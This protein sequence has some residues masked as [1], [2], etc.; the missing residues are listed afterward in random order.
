MI[1]GTSG[2]ETKLCQPAPSQ[3]KS[4]QTRS[5]SLGSRKTVA[6]FDPCCFRFS[7][8]LVEKIFTNRSKSSTC[9][10]AKIISLLLSVLSAGARRR[11]SGESAPRTPER[12]RANALSGVNE[13]VL[14][15]PDRRGGAAADA[16]LLVDVLDV[17][18]DG[19]GRDAEMRGDLL[20]GLT[21]H[22]HE[23]DFQLALGQPGRQ[24]VRSLLHAVAGGI[25]HR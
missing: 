4:T 1:A 20:I 3:S 6:P 10:V 13:V 14:E 9:V 7:A 12:H 21:A 16:G 8:P 24:L 17:V 23:Q 22:E 25:E 19:L 2:S 5:S 15:R 11:W 18:P